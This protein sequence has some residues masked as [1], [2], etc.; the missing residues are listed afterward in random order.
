MLLMHIMR[1]SSGRQCLCLRLPRSGVVDGGCIR[2]SAVR[3]T[4][5]QNTSILII[6]L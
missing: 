1:E 6:S 2:T 3:G 5:S 4:V